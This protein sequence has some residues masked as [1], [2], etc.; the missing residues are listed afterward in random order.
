MYD[1][2]SSEEISNFEIILSTSIEEILKTLTNR[3]NNIQKIHVKHRLE[4]REKIINDMAK[5]LEQEKLNRVKS[6]IDLNFYLEQEK[7]KISTNG[8][9]LFLTIACFMKAV[10]L[11]K[12]YETAHFE[13]EKEVN[14]MNAR[15][16]FM[17]GNKYYEY[18]TKRKLNFNENRLNDLARL[19]LSDNIDIGILESLINKCS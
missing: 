15:L 6:V 2:F 14:L 12:V 8:D 16:S 5:F 11:N 3:K 18:V 1:I 4:N 9:D 7:V 17:V 19:I 10:I 13:L